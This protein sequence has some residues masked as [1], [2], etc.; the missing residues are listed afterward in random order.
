MIL[1]EPLIIGGNTTAGR[2]LRKFS[3]AQIEH[4]K[5]HS[6]ELKRYISLALVEYQKEGV[7]MRPFSF[8]FRNYAAY[9]T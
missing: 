2:K 4:Y 3:E 1:E 7:K 8:F 6:T 5:S 9:P